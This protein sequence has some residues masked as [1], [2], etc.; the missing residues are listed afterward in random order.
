MIYVLGWD[1]PKCCICECRWLII[2][3]SGRLS[4]IRLDKLNLQYFLRRSQIPKIK[5]NLFEILPLE[6]CVCGTKIYVFKSCNRVYSFRS[7]FFYKLVKTPAG[8]SGR[9]RLLYN[10]EFHMIL[11][12]A[13]GETESLSTRNQEPSIKLA[14][15]SSNSSVVRFKGKKKQKKMYQNFLWTYKHTESYF[16]YR[17]H[18][19][20]YNLSW[21]R[22]S[23]L[24]YL[25][26]SRDVINP[27]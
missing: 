5:S 4:A 11:R 14:K 15:F 27:L 17:I 23:L 6:D 26:C 24:P 7:G 25:L 3:A 19:N 8:G 1:I 13:L 21:L 18:K 9:L 22:D 10:I 2:C 20:I 16:L 12:K